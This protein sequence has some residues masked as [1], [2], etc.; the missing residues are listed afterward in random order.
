M[1]LCS[2][3][4]GLSTDARF[5]VVDNENASLL[6][7]KDTAIVLGLL[8]V[9]A[10]AFTLGDENFHWYNWYRASFPRGS[11]DNAILQYFW[12]GLQIHTDPDVT[13]V[14]Q[15]LE[16]TPFH[17]RRSKVTAIDRPWHHRKCR[18]SYPVGVPVGVPL[19]GGHEAGQ[20]SGGP[21]ATPY[22]NFRRDLTGD[23]WSQGIF[24]T[25]STME[26]PPKWAARRLVSSYH[27]FYSHGPQALQASNLRFVVGFRAIPVH[28]SGN[29]TRHCR[30]PKHF[31]RHL[32][33]GSGITR[34]QPRRDFQA[35]TR[36]WTY[37]E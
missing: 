18:A 34:P 28:H 8:R 13:P 9:G 33:Q 21:W 25:R 5:V 20:W 19:G 27:V 16:R 29:P 1:H 30:R 36:V 12:R 35:I 2:C 31:R 11:V 23:E 6:L 22:T 14:A 32:R 17:R 10:G 4:T 26:L 15:R 37:S 3:S 7:C 24:E